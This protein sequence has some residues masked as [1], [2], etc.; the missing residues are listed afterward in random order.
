MQRTCKKTLK[1][2]YNA[3]YL[4][5]PLQMMYFS[6]FPPVGIIMTILQKSRKAVRRTKYREQNMN[7]IVLVPILTSSNPVNYITRKNRVKAERD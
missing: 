6:Y 5:T 4:K 3:N 1:V 7:G 2:K